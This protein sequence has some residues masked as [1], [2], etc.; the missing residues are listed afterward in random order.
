MQFDFQDYAAHV[1]YAAAVF[2]WCGFE[3]MQHGSFVALKIC[4]LWAAGLGAL[5]LVGLVGLVGF[6]GPSSQITAKQ[7]DLCNL[8]GYMTAWPQVS[9]IAV[10][11]YAV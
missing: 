2:V 9:K 6:C 8:W 10:R 7:H 5:G 11:L 1:V 4:S 3:F